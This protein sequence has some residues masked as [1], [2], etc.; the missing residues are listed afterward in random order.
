MQRCIHSTPLT[1]QE[2]TTYITHNLFRYFQRGRSC[3]MSAGMGKVSRKRMEGVISVCASW[4]IKRSF[5]YESHTKRNLNRL[6]LRDQ[7]MTGRIEQLTLALPQSH[8]HP[9]H[10]VPPLCVIRMR[11][12]RNWCS[13]HLVIKKNNWKLLLPNGEYSVI[14]NARNGRKFHVKTKSGRFGSSVAVQKRHQYC[15]QS[16]TWQ[17]C[18]REGRV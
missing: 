13:S 7:K 17:I 11:W 5:H 4:S 15:L 1:H 3:I 12:K 18:P 6:Q 10:L 14:G 2:T 9:N 16:C 8:S